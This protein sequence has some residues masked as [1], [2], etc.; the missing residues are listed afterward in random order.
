[1]HG[2]GLSDNGEPA[3]YETLNAADFADI[4]ATNR[5]GGRFGSERMAGVTR[6]ISY[7]TD[8][9]ARSNFGPFTVLDGYYFILGEYRDNSYDSRDA[10]CGCVPRDWILGRVI[11]DGRTSP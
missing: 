6:L 2:R 1:M 5:V 11:G 9:S 8:G 3:T 4:A 10:R 7:D